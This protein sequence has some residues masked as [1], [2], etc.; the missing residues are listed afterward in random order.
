MNAKKW[1][2]KAN[3][4]AEYPPLIF[5]MMN[6]FKQKISKKWVA[7]TTLFLGLFWK[8]NLA[9]AAG[10]LA[11]GAGIFAVEAVMKYL[12]GV[13]ITGMTLQGLIGGVIA[14]L[15]YTIGGILTVL[16]WILF[17]AAKYS[18]FI[19]APV[20]QGGWVVIRDISNMFFILILLIIAFATILRLES[21]SWKKN[22]PKLLIMAVLINFSKTICGLAI[23]FGQVIMLT[24]INAF[25]DAGPGN[26]ITTFGVEKLYSISLIADKDVSALNNLGSLLL[27]LI[28]LIITSIVVGVFA[29][30]L[31]YRIVMLWI[32]IILSPLAFLAMAIPA[33]AKY[34]SQ[35]TGE[36]AK[37]IVVGPILAF[38][39]WLALL[40]GSSST[41]GVD[42]I[43]TNDPNVPNATISKM[44]EGNNMQK[45]IVA[46]ALLFGGL[47]MAQQMGG[48][49]GS[50]AGKGLDWAKKS[51]AAPFAG[52]LL[53]AKTLAGYG[54]DKIHEKTGVDLNV[55]RVWTGIQEKRAEI[56]KKRYGRGMIKASEA[57]R[58]RGRIY[59]ALAMTGTPGQAWEQLTTGAGWKRRIMGG[60]YAK[61]K[62]DELAERREAAKEEIKKAE[63]N[64]KDRKSYQKSEEILSEPSKYTEE[65]VNNARHIKQTLDEEIA[66]QIKPFKHEIENINDQILN[67]KPMVD[68][69]AVATQ[70]ALEAEE[71]K[72]V[73][74]IKDREELASMLRDAMKKRDKIRFAAIALKLTKD[75]NE[76]D[77][78]LNNLGFNS[79]AEGLNKM[80]DSISDKNHKNYM[81]FSDQEAKA[82]GMKMAYS[83]EAN[84]HWGIARSFIMEDGRYRNASK[85]EQ[86]MAAVSEIA[87]MDPQR[88]ALGLNRLG[89]GGE[90]PDGKFI[91]DEFGLAVAKTVGPKVTEQMSRFNP[92]ASARL[93]TK[94]N[95][96]L[97]KKA[98]VAAEF[99]NGLS[100]EVDSKGNKRTKTISAGQAIEELKNQGMF[101]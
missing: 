62:I 32:L 94:E 44:G 73:E 95:I 30:I 18:D 99:I 40:Y 8:I 52:G 2:V 34:A 11:V 64:I 14:I 56:R 60:K 21:Y 43:K 87:K 57:M 9:K 39:L 84:N 36:L 97:M 80:I 86:T 38:F 33:G 82:L 77:G 6:S 92:N 29:I 69:D 66:R 53:G 24:F 4:T 88:I 67:Y 3:R 83:G 13:T 75:G 61:G 93:S 51:A 26:V 76:N 42:L 46:I 7:I 71:M 41:I 5:D 58:D 50:I 23:D 47:M 10:P 101:K 59:G 72:K 74:H 85:E 37:N 15:V 89:Y 16:I 45:F 65:N 91:L 17:Q 27:G 96:E 28:M 22:L 70:G 81:G 49:V 63:K 31:V 90:T 1:S 12:F 54:I 68:F 19:N 79:N 98:G 48:A 20:V 78:V 25:G 55:A 100:S 35:W